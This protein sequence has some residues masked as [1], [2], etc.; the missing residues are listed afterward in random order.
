MSSQLFET[1][2]AQTLRS[3]TSSG[4]WNRLILSLVPL[5][6]FK[7]AREEIVSLY[8][9]VYSEVD[10]VREA[11]SEKSNPQLRDWAVE[12][13]SQIPEYDPHETVTE[14]LSFPRKVM[15][16]FK[17]L[18]IVVTV[19]GSLV[20][21]DWLRSL[22]RGG[23]GV[24]EGI[25]GLVP[26]SFIAISIVY[27]WFLHADTRAHQ[28][29]GKELRTGPARVQTRQRPQIVG[30]GLWNRS[31]L[32]QSGLLLVAII[33]LLNSFSKL[34]VI[35]RWFDDPVNYVMNLITENVESLY[36]A[37]STLE[38]CCILSHQLW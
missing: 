6:E 13:H 24:I 33:F 29:L 16:W 18:S 26:L 19:A 7:D 38:A 23:L 36:E 5:D 22:G 32:G 11:F 35:Q 27:L 10:E 37:D 15:S 25:E 8:G 21:V 30:Y 3:I 4:L 34:P 9:K 14:L 17:R 31:L 2:P 20:S 12:P 28:T 1:H